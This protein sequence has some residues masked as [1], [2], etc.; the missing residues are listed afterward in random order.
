M[1]Q[2]NNFIES[3]LLVNLTTEYHTH[4]TINFFD[5]NIDNETYIVSP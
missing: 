3:L 1:T 5:K 4:V 2:I